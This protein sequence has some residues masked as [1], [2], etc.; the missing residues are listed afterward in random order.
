MEVTDC[1]VERALGD[2]NRLF[3]GDKTRLLPEYGGYGGDDGK[4]ESAVEGFL[5]IDRVSKLFESLIEERC[6]PHEPQHF[7]KEWVCEV[8]T[9]LYHANDQD[10][11]TLR[12]LIGEPAPQTIGFMLDHIHNDSFPGYWW[13]HKRWIPT[14]PTPSNLQRILRTIVRS[15]CVDCTNKLRQTPLHVACLENG[16]GRTQNFDSHYGVIRILSRVGIISLPDVRQKTPYDYLLVPKKPAAHR[17][18]GSLLRESYLFDR[19]GDLIGSLWDDRCLREEKA[20]LERCNALLEVFCTVAECDLPPLPKPAAN[21]Y[22]Q[23]TKVEDLLRSSDIV[24]SFGGYDEYVVRTDQR[25][26]YFH[27]DTLRRE[28]LAVTIQRAFRRKFGFNTLSVIESRSISITFVKPRLFWMGERRRLGWEYFRKCSHLQFQVTLQESEIWSQYFNLKFGETFF[29]CEETDVYQWNAPVRRRKTEDFS[30]EKRKETTLEIGDTVYFKFANDKDETIC[31]VTKK[32]K[33]TG[34]C[35]DKNFLYDIIESCGGINKER[36]T[37]KG[38]D[39]LFLRKTLAKSREDDQ[40]KKMI[41][42]WKKALAHKRKK[43]Q[44]RSRVV[45]KSILLHRDAKIMSIR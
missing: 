3:H 32:V 18:S 31:L 34:E 27:S 10:G 9:R 44:D 8:V 14:L 16:T 43:D 41:E 21:I 24:R 15:S 20:S 45:E 39:R 5:G 40:A 28:R 6:E 17:P 13:S 11:E 26:F 4:G 42:E 19:R 37:I 29:F 33:K 30:D 7:R 35:N 23:T 2:V 38:C 12:K 1:L 25:V 36:L 22:L